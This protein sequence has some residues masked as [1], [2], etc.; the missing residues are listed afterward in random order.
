VSITAKPQIS[1]VGIQW[2]DSLHEISLVAPYFFSTMRGRKRVNLIKKLNKSR[3][4]KG[5]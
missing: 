2:C 3:M 1:L 4:K 5:R